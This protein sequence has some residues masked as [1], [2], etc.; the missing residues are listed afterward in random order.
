MVI[1]AKDDI[2]HNHNESHVGNQ[3]AVYP[4]D[5]HPAHFQLELNHVD[6]IVLVE[7][8]KISSPTA[9]NECKYGLPVL[10]CINQAAHTRG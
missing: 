1:Q 4:Y 2:C 10:P 9:T 8:R 6:F 7:E 5:H 3:K